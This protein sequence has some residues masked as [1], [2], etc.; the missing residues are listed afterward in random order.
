MLLAALTPGAPRGLLGPPLGP[1]G[2]L[3]ALG[4]PWGLLGPQLMKRNGYVFFD[5]ELS[6]LP[7]LCYP[8]KDS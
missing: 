8:V 4:A 2:P 3:G 6:L 7:R 5:P 1:L